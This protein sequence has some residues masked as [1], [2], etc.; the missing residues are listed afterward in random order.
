MARHRSAR[1]D[2]E[3]LDRRDRLG[4]QSPAL[5]GIER[6]VGRE[7]TTRR[8]ENRHGRSWSAPLAIERSVGIEHLEVIAAAAA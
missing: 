1:A 3:R 2:I 6:R 8:S 5:L 7:Q 4:D